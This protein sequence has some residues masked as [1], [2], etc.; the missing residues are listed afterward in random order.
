MLFV[1]GLILLEVL[2]VEDRFAALIVERDIGVHAT[3]AF[4]RVPR[5]VARAKGRSVKKGF[6][7]VV[8][9]VKQ[10]NRAGSVGSADNTRFLTGLL[11]AQRGDSRTEDA[12]FPAVDIGLS[13]R[14]LIFGPGPG[15]R[16]GRY[17]WLVG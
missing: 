10:G 5:N 17:Y 13:S 6:Q 15:N 9:M 7:A 2:L 4:L 14:E 11:H 1:L 3:E 8:H 12:P 16:W